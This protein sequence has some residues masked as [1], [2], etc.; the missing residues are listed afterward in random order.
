LVKIEDLPY[1][2]Q[3]RCMQKLFK[4]VETLPNSHPKLFFVMKGNQDTYIST[5]LNRDETE[6]KQ[7]TCSSLS[8]LIK[9]IAAS[10]KNIYVVC[11]S[12]CGEGKTT[13]VI[14]QLVCDRR[15]DLGQPILHA[16]F[17]IDL[18]PMM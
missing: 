12:H 10:R 15:D 4:I 13:S 17:S 16:Q 18:T 2:T 9:P 1:P 11:S 8:S 6:F 7:E 3:T 5:I 14:R